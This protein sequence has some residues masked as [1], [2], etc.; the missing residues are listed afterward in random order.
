MQHR[1]TFVSFFLCQFVLKFHAC[2][3]SPG[4]LRLILWCQS[5]LFRDLEPNSNKTSTIKG[6]TSLNSHNSIRFI[7]YAMSLTRYHKF[8]Q[9]TSFMLTYR[10]NVTIF[11]EI[12]LIPSYS[13]DVWYLTVD[14][15][16]M[17]S[18]WNHLENSFSENR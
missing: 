16:S 5:L 2:N 14:I 18:P 9:A 3:C 4:N 6:A 1:I 11:L 8:S 15:K 17:S 12:F 7:R 13:K 10:N